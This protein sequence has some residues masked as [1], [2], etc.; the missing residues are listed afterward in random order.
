MLHNRHN[1]CMYILIII[2]YMSLHVYLNFRRKLLFTNNYYLQTIIIY[3]NY[4]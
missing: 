3:N 1:I 2:L 4:Y